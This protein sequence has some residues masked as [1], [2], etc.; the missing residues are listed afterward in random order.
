[1]LHRIPVEIMRDI[2]ALAASRPAVSW[3]PHLKWASDI[4]WGSYV[5]TALALTQVCKSWHALGI[6]MLY[7]DVI[8][9]S[10]LQFPVFHRTL[11]AS[12]RDYGWLMRGLS[13]SCLVDDS[14]DA[15]VHEF[16]GEILDRCPRLERLSLSQE[17]QWN[18]RQY[19]RID[20]ASTLAPNL[21]HLRLDDFAGPF[22][23]YAFLAS[24][25]SLESLTASWPILSPFNR[26]VVIPRLRDLTLILVGLKYRHDFLT[27]SLPSLQ[28]LTICITD[29]QC[30]NQTSQL[31]KVISRL[32]SSYGQ[33]LRRLHFNY[34]AWTDDWDKLEDADDQAFIDMCPNLEHF[35]TYTGGGLGLTHH[36]TLKYIDAWVP[37]FSLDGLDDAHDPKSIFAAEDATFPA[38]QCCRTLDISLSMFMELPSVI[39]PHLAVSP[40]ESYSRW[41]F[42]GLQIAQTAHAVTWASPFAYD[43]D[44]DE[45][46]VYSSPSEDDFDSDSD[47]WAASD[48]F[49]SDGEEEEGEDGDGASAEEWV[50]DGLPRTSCMGARTEAMVARDVEE[51]IRTSVAELVK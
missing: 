41:T 33:P 30:Q 32:L 10:M 25:I 22:N 17:Y 31:R 34:M 50:D 18:W 43:S 40:T 2:F 11:T 19:D 38:L 1:M 29:K 48:D 12:S 14:A 15:L 36:P 49:S 23:N 51:R 26:T 9:D 42:G 44:E 6:E 37:P 47:G 27:F 16:F 21:T 8:L 13:I 4:C 3:N 5:R 45:A 39:A 28:S 35:I 20:F 7:G 24:C 46:Y